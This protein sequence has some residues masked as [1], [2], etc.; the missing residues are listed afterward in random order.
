MRAFAHRPGAARRRPPDQTAPREERAIDP[1]ETVPTTP[2]AGARR[3]FPELLAATGV[4]A[5]L[6]VA[7]IVIERATRPAGG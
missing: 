3:R 4:G 2:A 1:T 7:A 6:V 5:A